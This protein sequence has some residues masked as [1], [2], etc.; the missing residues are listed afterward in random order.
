MSRTVRLG[1][2]LLGTEGAA[3]FRCL[4]DRDDVFIGERVAAIRKFAAEFDGYRLSAGMQVPELDV[5]EGYAAWAPTYDTMKNGLIR[6]E[7]PVVA[8]V[9]EDLTVGVALDAAC[10]T[11][12]HAAW[13]ARAGHV[14]T[15]IDASPAMLDIA[16][17][18]LP[19][20]DFRLGDLKQLP[21]DDGAFDFAI[22]ALAL[23]HLEQPQAAIRELAR[24]VRP[25]GRIVLTDVHPTF[26]LIQGQALFP[27]TRGLAFVRN[28][29][30]LHGVYLD[31]IRTTGLSVLDC[32][33]A[34]MEADFTTGMFAEVADAAAALWK[35]IPAVLVW[36][37]HK[38]G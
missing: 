8:S 20:T 3:L 7:E 30:H 36:S 25:G 17:L 19:T 22:C 11:G 33:E 23:T 10:G 26:V 9:T 24:V 15:G 18:R 28:Y 6:A 37:L 5:A 1:E 21:F 4:L 29:P 16:R 35:D 27:S 32:R 12:R 34:P 2:L 14:T 13:L 38:P 31:A